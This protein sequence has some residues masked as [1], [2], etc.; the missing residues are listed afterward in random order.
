MTEGTLANWLKKEGDTI[1]SGEVIAEVET[2]KAMMDLEAFESG[3]LRKILIT[4]GTKVPINTP[5]A[6]LTETPD[7]H[8]ETPPAVPST[9]PA[10]PPTVA[11][12]T[13][14][15]PPDPAASHQPVATSAPALN[16]VTSPISPP[17][18][19]TSH[20]NQRQKISPLAK[21]IAQNQNIPTHNIIGTGPG[22]RIVKRDVL[23]AAQNLASAT[24]ALFPSGPI[25]RDERI[26]LT[27]MRQTIARRL[28][29][30][31]T[32]IPHFY[33]QI[34][35]NADALVHTR[36][37]LNDA[38]A[39]LPDPVK[40]SYNDFV[41][42][43]AV[44]ALRAV[45]TVNS[46]FEGDAIRQH[47]EVHLAFAVALENGLITPVIRSASSKNIR[48]IS[49]ETKNLAAKAREGKLKP[50][51]Y[52]GGTF[53]VS[54]LG[55]MGIDA[56][57]AIINPPQAAILAVGNI[58][59]KAVVDEHDRIVVG[60]RMS[61][62]LSCDHRIVDGSV[63]AQFLAQIRRFLENPVLLIA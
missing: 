60:H 23:Q 12:P 9:P 56:F 53:T 31:K 24:P 36:A 49:I 4:P 41:M 21:K 54:N 30:S 48:Q 37:A 35:I 58:V 8:F 63:G 27:S 61:L 6:I 15:P 2:D 29:E 43:A 52:I 13:P 1:K 18:A 32:Q 40:L 59:K 47:A 46:S 51:D 38:L 34:E 11:T 22:G 45:P 39:A 10:T 26:P 14:P 7:E 44:Q 3:V 50:E 20:T 5:I 42:K 25:A 28:L 17:P 33:L 16:L 62:T 19:T 57:S 55:M